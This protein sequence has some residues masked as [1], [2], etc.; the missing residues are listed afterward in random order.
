MT[1]KPDGTSI[2]VLVLLVAKVREDATNMPDHRVALVEEPLCF[3]GGRVET[4]LANAD[5]GR[6]SP[7]LSLGSGDGGLAPGPFHTDLGEH[8]VEMMHS[9]RRLLHHGHRPIAR[10]GLCDVIMHENLGRC[11][12]GLG[13]RGLA[14]CIATLLLHRLLVRSSPRRR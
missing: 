7:G 3:L 10:L 11:L 14:Y 6:G 1:R 8:H 2:A 12:L 5:P 9:S 13:K 4:C